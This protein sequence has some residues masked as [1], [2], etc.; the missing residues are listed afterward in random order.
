MENN[1]WRRHKRNWGLIVGQGNYSVGPEGSDA[2]C[3]RLGE[4]ER[5]SKFIHIERIFAGGVSSIEFVMSL[6]DNAVWAGPTMLDAKDQ[7]FPVD[8]AVLRQNSARL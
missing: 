4:R 7:S 5:G 6:K 3:N 8:K 2:L 1:S